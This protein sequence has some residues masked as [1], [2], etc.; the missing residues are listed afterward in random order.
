MSLFIQ[1][2]WT[3]LWLLICI[4]RLPSWRIWAPTIFCEANY[5]RLWGTWN[6]FKIK[7]IKIKLARVCSLYF[8]STHSN[9]RG[10]LPSPRF[11]WLAVSWF[12]S[13]RSGFAA[14]S[15]GFRSSAS[16]FQ[17]FR[18]LSRMILLLSLAPFSLAHLIE[19]QR[20]C[21]RSSVS[22]SSPQVSLSNQ[23]QHSLFFVCHPFAHLPQSEIQVSAM[24]P[25]SPLP[26]TSS[27]WQ[28]VLIN[29]S[30]ICYFFKS[31]PSFSSH[32]CLLHG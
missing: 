7:G 28:I 16:F 15:S 8:S 18:L 32:C 22:V 5:A 11:L 4:A 31:P 24:I 12:P 29:T 27:K 20:F 26:A 19:S 30:R 14:C 6:K 17:V 10:Y 21:S 2:V 25:S 13:S 1:R 23:Y 3:L 9:H